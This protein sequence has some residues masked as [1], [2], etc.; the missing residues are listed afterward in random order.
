MAAKFLFLQ[1]LL[2]I[3][4]YPN[5]EIYYRELTVMGSYSPAPTDLKESL[6]L[7]KSGKVKVNDISSI[8][9]LENINQAFEDTISNKVLKAYIK[10][11]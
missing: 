5:N 4:G 11:N 2:K 6:E 9:E 10:I 7:L 1:A 8:Y 3:S